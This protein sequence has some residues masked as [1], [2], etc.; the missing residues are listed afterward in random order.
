VLTDPDKGE[1]IVV[2]F[3]GTE[4]DAQAS[5]TNASYIGQISMMSS[6]LY[7]PLA[8]RTYEANVMA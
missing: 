4:A 8:P 5:E 6:F 7:E 1:G 3:W 2:S